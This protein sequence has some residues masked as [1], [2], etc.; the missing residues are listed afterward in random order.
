L[1]KRYEVGTGQLIDVLDAQQ[2]LLE[3][4]IELIDRAIELAEADVQLKA[5]M[6]R[7]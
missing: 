5:S 1:R 2:K 6:G 7:F 3:S 4:E